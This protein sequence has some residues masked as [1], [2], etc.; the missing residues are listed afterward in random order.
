M[1]VEGPT[2]STDSREIPIGSAPR[3]SRSFTAGGSRGRFGDECVSLCGGAF[4][5]GFSR[6]AQGGAGD[7]ASQ[8]INKSVGCCKPAARCGNTDALD[9][10]S[11]EKRASEQAAFISRKRNER[12]EF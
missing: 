5:R 11:R 2:S 7:R 6:L 1:D 4:E 8:R 9:P 3:V 12:W 10:S